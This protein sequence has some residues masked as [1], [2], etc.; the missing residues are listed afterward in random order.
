[1]KTTATKKLLT[2]QEFK[3][4]LRCFLINEYNQTNHSSI[5]VSPIKKWSEQLFLPNMPNS[6]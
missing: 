3:E 2:I 4:K 6:L 1:M 5:K